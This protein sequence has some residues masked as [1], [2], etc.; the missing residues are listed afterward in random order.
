MKQSVLKSFCLLIAV[1]FAVDVAAQQ[2][3]A[4]TATGKANGATVTINYS[5]PSVRGRK[6]WGELVPYGKVW[7]AGANQ[8]TTVEFDKDVTIEG[9]KVPKGKYSLYAIPGE[10][11]WS[12][13]LNSQTGQWGITRQGETTRDESKDVA[14]V[15]VKPKKSA[16]MT[17]ALK[18]EVNNNG[19]SLI[20]ENLEVPVSVKG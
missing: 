12:I 3:P 20:W 14:V 6:V 2:S 13:V 18:Y 9:K 4:A 10:K 8:A 5:S 17:E 7:R 11:E 19:F 15:T 1:L 16:S